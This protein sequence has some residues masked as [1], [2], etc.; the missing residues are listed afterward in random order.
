MDIFQRCLWYSPA[1]L[2]ARFGNLRA[3]GAFLVSSELENGKVQYVSITSEQGRDCAVQNPW[4]DKEVK[5]CRGGRKWETAGGERL[6]LKTKKGEI[7]T[8][9]PE[10]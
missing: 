3:Y 8:L 1:G 6:M 2:D 7:V 4:P 9:L 5:I 10:G